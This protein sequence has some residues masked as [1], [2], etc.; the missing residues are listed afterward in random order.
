[1]LG[2]LFPF[3]SKVILKASQSQ[4]VKEMVVEL[5]EKI[6]ANTDNDLDDVIVAKLKKA[7]MEPTGTPI[8]QQ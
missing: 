6:V 2:L 7:I 4:S 1:M 5:L 8:S 3:A